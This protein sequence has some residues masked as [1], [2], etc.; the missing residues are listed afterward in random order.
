MERV[1][2]LSAPVL[3]RTVRFQVKATR[4]VKILLLAHKVE[5]GPSSNHLERGAVLCV[6]QHDG[7]LMSFNILTVD[8]VLHGR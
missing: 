6:K 7:G 1:V 2:V 8:A 3:G 5:P 4:S